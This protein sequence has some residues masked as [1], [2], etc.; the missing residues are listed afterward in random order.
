MRHPHSNRFNPAPLALAVALALSAPAL[1]YAQA[2]ANAK[3]VAI[4]ISIAAQPLGDAL[5]ELGAAIGASSVAF[6]HA[7]V[8]GK[9]APAVK[10]VLTAPQA[11]ERLLVGSG[12]VGSINNGVLTVRQAPQPGGEATLSPVTVT[13]QA[14]R[15]DVTEGTGSYVARSSSVGS[16]TGQSLREVPQSVSV[17]TR[18]Q[19]EDQGLTTLPDA[20]KAMPGVTSFQGAMLTDRSH[21]RGFEMGAANMRVDGGAVIE[22]GFGIDN[23]LAFYDRVE[24]LRGADGLFGGNG[25]PGG[26]VNLVRKKPTREKQII[27]QGQYGSHNFKRADLDVSGPLTEDGHVRGRAVLAHEDKGFFFDV[28]HSKRS[29]AYGVLEADLTRDTTVTV[30]ATYIKR[31]SSFQGYGLPRA[32][33]GEDL[34]LPRTTYLSGA[35]DRANKDIK[36][37][38]GQVAH[39]FNDDWRLDVAL[40]HESSMQERYDHYFNGAP[41][42]ATGFGTRGGANLQDESW[43]NSSIDASLKGRFGFL[44]RQHDL[45]I[46]ADWSKLQQQSDMQRPVPYVMDTIPNVYQFNPYAYRQSAAPMATWAKYSL[47]VEQS[48]IYGSARFHVADPLRVIVGGRVSRYHY[49][50]LFNTFDTSGVQAGSDL[51]DYR[52]NSVF[53]PYLAATYDL[54]KTWTAYGSVA[55]TF[56]SQAGSRSGPA[57][58]KPLDPIT[59]RNYELGIKGS[60]LGGRLQSA[61]AIYRIEREGAAVRD[62]NYPDSSGPLGSS[63]CFLG[64]GQIVSKGFDAELTGELV[65]DLNVS[66]SYSYNDNRNKNAE[67]QPRYN[68]VNPEHLVKVFASYRLQGALSRWKL[69]GGITAQSKTFVDGSAYLRNPDG[70]VSN[71]MAKYRFTQRGYAIASVHVDY[72]INDQW[73]ASLN[74]N[75]LFDKTYYSTI[76]TLTYGSFYGAPRNAMLTLRGRF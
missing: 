68:G 63:C 3:P 53:T 24:V 8:A 61:F 46:G 1:T 62:T 75:N 56:M 41:D 22:R 21:S 47:P 39:R 42:L 69:G 32:R 15:S 67:G 11:L 34:G 44:G 49:R 38:F 52:D 65:R 6:S 26:V 18:Q 64:N 45:V 60:H 7:L 36:T 55:E 59:G 4:S 25:E 16:K 54:N 2:A 17:V 57:P 58:G 71:Q 43:R 12:L 23:D 5:N 33:T 29:L 19:I 74:V 35:D 73:T 27:V 70:T 30:G 48:G 13:A 50:Y 40:N 51:T 37:V 10:G 28:A 9:T 31:D 72:Q 20:L 76:G 66:F 14:D